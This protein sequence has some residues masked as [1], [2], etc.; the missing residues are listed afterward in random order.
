MT[1]PTCPKCG[2]TK[3]PCHF[4]APGVSLGEGYEQ[5]LRGICLRCQREHAEAQLGGSLGIK[6]GGN[7]L[8]EAGEQLAMLRDAERRAIERDPSLH[9][10]L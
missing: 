9:R 4:Q 3:A 8:K 2:Q 7:L 1:N 6:L 10:P 5:F